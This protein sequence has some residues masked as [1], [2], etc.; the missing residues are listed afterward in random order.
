M[1]IDVSDGRQKE[2]ITTRFG[3]DLKKENTERKSQKISTCNG[4]MCPNPENG[5]DEDVS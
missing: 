1:H 5:I 2:S 3:L 4:A